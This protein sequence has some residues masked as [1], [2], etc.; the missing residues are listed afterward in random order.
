MTALLVALGVA[1]LLLGVA[2]G[3]GAALYWQH[4]ERE[5]RAAA[6]GVAVDIRLDELMARLAGSGRPLQVVAATRLHEQNVQLAAA[7]KRQAELLTTSLE[8][9]AKL[10]NAQVAVAKLTRELDEVKAKGPQRPPTPFR[11]GGG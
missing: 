8:D 6:D 3:F 4:R 11:R 10:A 2:G 9:R 1:L 5:R 7:I